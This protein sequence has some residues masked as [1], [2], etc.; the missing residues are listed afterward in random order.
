HLCDARRTSPTGRWM[1]R[2]DMA[3]APRTFPRA[4]TTDAL[5]RPSDLARHWEL[6]PKTVY[7]WIKDGR[8]PAVRTPGDQFR[9][10]VSDV[11]AFCEPSGLRPPTHLLPETGRVVVLARPGAAVRALRQ[12]L[13]SAQVRVESYGRALDGLFAVVRAPPHVL[14]I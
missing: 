13:R 14:V 9:L 3:T 1:R 6:H 7:L 11:L 8:L 10:R 5:V 4:R 12:A 2:W